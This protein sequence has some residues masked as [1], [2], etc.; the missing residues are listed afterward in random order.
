M[1]DGKMAAWLAAVGIVGGG[2]G[3]LRADSVPSEMTLSTP[4]YAAASDGDIQAGLLES[5]MRERAG[6]GGWFDEYGLR[7]TGHAAAGFTYNFMRPPGGTNGPGRIFDDKSDDPTLNQIDLKLTREI[8][9][10]S[11]R[12][13]IGFTVELIFGSDARYTQA[14]GTN[15]YGS[16]YAHK[17]DLSF[18]VAGGAPTTFIESGGFPGQGDP[19]NQFDFLQANLTLNLPVGDGMMLTMGKMVAPLGYESIDPTKNLL[20]SH[21][22]IFGLAL[23]RT[24]TGVTAGYRV[25]ENWT[26]MGGVIVGWDQAFQDVNDTPSYIFQAGYRSSEDWDATITT[27]FGPEQ[28]DEDGDW[29]WI[30]DATWHWKWSVF[31]FGA[32]GTIGYEP[33][34]GTE[35]RDV[36][37][38][39]FEFASL[40]EFTGKDAWWWGGAAYASFY[41]DETEQFKLVGRVEYFND[42]VGGLLF[43]SEVYSATVGL[44]IVPFP[45]HEIGRNLMIRPEVRYDYALDE[46]FDGG[47]GLEGN[48]RQSQITV[49]GD[50]IFTF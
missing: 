32:E 36:E 26:V 23:P 5:Q 47:G 44:N 37:V 17:R 38:A 49:G 20:Y 6:V 41:I 34:V 43:S 30:V 45:R 8:P 2:Y 21:S 19:E 18:F 42:A 50:I 15:F 25:D 33:N 35:F 10:S 22:F 1:S 28:P 39:A 13:E 31:S 4:V 16:G 48:G 9:Y 24:I 3:I 12:F 46:V 27:I 11:D 14:N 40:R 7:L 29:R